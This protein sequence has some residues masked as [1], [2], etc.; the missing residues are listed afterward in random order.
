MF[1]QILVPVDLT[2]VHGRA[3]DIAAALAGTAAGTVTVLHVIELIAGLPLEEGKDFY[4]QLEKKA[5]AHVANLGARLAGKGVPWK[6]EVVFGNRTAEI[7]R[8]A[9]Q[10]DTDLIVLTSHRIDL[11]HATGG[12]GTLSHWIGML[13]PCPVLL[14]K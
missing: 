6:A 3:M 1:K 11:Q 8:Y 2:D 5:Q 9:Q 12:L 7:L 14:A 13:A 4:E 10:N